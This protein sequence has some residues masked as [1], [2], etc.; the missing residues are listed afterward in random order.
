[1]PLAGS[2]WLSIEV[3]LPAKVTSGCDTGTEAAA[4]PG[5]ICPASRSGSQTFT[6]SAGESSIETICVCDV[7]ALP[8][9][10]FRMPSTP[11]IGAEI[12]RV[13]QILIG[14]PNRQIRHLGG[15]F[16]RLGLIGRGG[17]AL[18]KRLVAIER[19]LGIISRKL[20]LFAGQLPGFGI[21]PGKDLPRRD[22]RSRGHGNLGQGV[23]GLGQ[24]NHRLQG[25]AGSQ[26]GH[27]GID[28]DRTCGL[29]N[30]RR[31]AALTPVARF[32][33]LRCRVGWRAAFGSCPSFTRR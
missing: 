6:T 29:H 15:H 1:M 23:I 33:A 7:T 16:H 27:F 21:Q 19:T 4:S 25:R 20:G 26:S 9:E 17:V 31:L 3:I 11:A 12:T 14:G 8:T 10:T 2:I 30:H 24:N 5:L 28:D 22:L 18:H 32:G 13:R